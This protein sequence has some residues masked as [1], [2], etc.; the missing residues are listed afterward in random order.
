M[1]E[2][3][4]DRQTERGIFVVVGTYVHVLRQ[5]MNVG[6]FVLRITEEERERM[7]PTR[8]KQKRND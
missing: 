5:A 4:L 2:C 1:K 8:Q 3:I 7:I 6:E